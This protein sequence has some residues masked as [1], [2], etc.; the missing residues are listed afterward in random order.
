MFRD[1]QGRSGPK[2]SKQISTHKDA[3]Q[4]LDRLV[5]RIADAV[6]DAVRCSE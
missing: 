3:A 1:F 4:E 5:K 2:M 6:H